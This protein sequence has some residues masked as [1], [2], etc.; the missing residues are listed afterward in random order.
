MI[1][2][3]LGDSEIEGV[4]EDEAFI[5]GMLSSELMYGYLPCEPLTSNQE[6]L[7]S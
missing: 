2:S 3:T 1:S 5:G 7:G 4:F 6:E